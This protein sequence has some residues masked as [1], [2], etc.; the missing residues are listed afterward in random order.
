MSSR[1][2]EFAGADSLLYHVPQ[3]SRREKLRFPTDESPASAASLLPLLYQ[4]NPTCLPSSYY[5]HNFDECGPHQIQPQ[6]FSLSLS[7]A[8]VGP[9][10]PFTGL[11]RSGFVQPARQLLE[12]ICR[13]GRGELAGVG[14]R[15]L[16][17]D[18]TMENEVGQRVGGFEDD[19]WKK[20]KLVSMLHEIHRRYRLYY[21]QVET[22]ITSFETVAGLNTAAPYVSLALKSMSKNF[23]SLKSIISDHLNNLD[24]IDAKQRLGKG[25]FTGFGLTATGDHAFSQRRNSSLTFGQPQVWRPQR[26]LPERAVSVLRAWLFEHFLHPYPTDT[27][28]QMLAKQTGLTRNQVSN[29]FINAR[30]R[31]WKPMVEEIHN[32][33]MHQLQKSVAETDPHN[34][35]NSNLQ[36]SHPSSSSAAA[37]TTSS[38]INRPPIQENNFMLR[39]NQNRSY[40]S[41]NIELPHM[42]E[43]Y[44]FVF[45]DAFAIHAQSPMGVQM[46]GN[47]VVSLT[48]GLSEP[49]S[50]NVARRFGLEE[51]SNAYDLHYGKEIGAHMLHDFVG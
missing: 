15:D 31:L 29:W 39:N 37:A 14:D 1:A 32:L 28:K 5:S 38:S 24:M 22:I 34:V 7:P 2:E 35:R 6:G 41:S 25:E 9:L 11:N 8:T 21:Q 19:Q 4:S 49:L 26:G 20:L 43:P 13:L 36:A 23:R 18:I 48:L 12:E 33:E 50:M 17:E 40:R 27:D 42:E 44:K 45:D 47:S 51:C 10:G 16:M 3:H 30:V 46:G